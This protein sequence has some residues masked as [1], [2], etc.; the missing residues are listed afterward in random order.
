MVKEVGTSIGQKGKMVLK[1]RKGPDAELTVILRNTV[2]TTINESKLYTN[3]EGL[4]N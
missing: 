3:C 1:T 4:K 2:S